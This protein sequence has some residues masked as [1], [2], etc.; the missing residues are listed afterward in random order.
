M[1]LSTGKINYVLPVYA[2]TSLLMACGKNENFKD[3]LIKVSGS[4]QTSANSNSLPAD[5][6]MRA[7]IEVTN[8]TIS[9]GV[10]AGKQ[11]NL[12]TPQALLLDATNL[13]AVLKPVFGDYG[14]QSPTDK[15]YFTVEKKANLGEYMLF[16]ALRMGAPIKLSQDYI[17]ELRHFAGRACN[18]LVTAESSAQPQT[19]KLIIKRDWES[20]TISI[21][22]INSFMSKSFGYSLVAGASHAGATDLQSIFNAAVAG[23]E[24]AN[25]KRTKD[26]AMKDNY[27]LL[28]VYVTTDPRTYSR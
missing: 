16:G 24:S 8:S 11:I 3:E 25:D 22:A 23:A 28:C 9:S 1:K 15:T 7:A 10:L 5:P 14:H 26:D 21:E 2:G 20:K 19:N 17:F 12:T 13:E 6:L 27:K 18:K 4:A